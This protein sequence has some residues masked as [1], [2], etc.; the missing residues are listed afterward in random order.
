MSNSRQRFGRSGEDA[1]VRHLKRHGYRILERN[2][3][4]PHGEIDIIA[5][6]GDVLVFIEVK[7]R[8]S[9]R[10]GPAKAA[11]TA[12]K[13][14]K[15]SMA[16]LAWLKASRKSDARARFDVVA[17]QADD[18]KPRIEVIQNAFELAYP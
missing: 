2:F 4:S 6:H 9:N 17:V 15:I 7:S 12:T 16:A 8:H 13:Q 5:R 3:R 10:F 14:R 18:A 11:V 1:A